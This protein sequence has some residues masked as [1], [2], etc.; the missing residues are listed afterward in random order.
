MKKLTLI[1]MAF[2]LIASMAFAADQKSGSTTVAVTV[3]A[4][5]WISVPSSTNLTNASGD[6]SAPFVGSTLIAY[7][8]RTSKTSGSG[9][10]TFKAAE[11]NPGGGPSITTLASAGDELNYTSSVSGVGTGIAAATNVTS[12]STDYNVVT[13]GSNARSAKAGESTTVSWTLPND[14]QYQTGSYTSV[15]TFT[16]SAT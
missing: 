13:F 7:K 14:P 8:V 12:T 16:I 11:F 4:E 6:F 3:G 9:A 10:I 1:I 15:V 5:A 2:A